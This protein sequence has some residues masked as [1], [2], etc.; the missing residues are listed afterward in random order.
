MYEHG[1]ASIALCECFGMTGDQRVG[2]AAQAALDFIAEAQDPSGGGWRYQPRTPGDTS[3]TGWQVMALKSGQ[4]A[5]LNVST[6][7]LEKAKQFLESVSSCGTGPHRHRRLLRLHRQEQ[8]NR[9]HQ[10]GRLAL[11]PIPGRAED[12]SGDDRRNRL[13]MQNHAGHRRP[14]RTSTTGTMPRR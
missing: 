12:R 4:M 10:R 2:Q 3:V 9:R 6:G 11:L 5:G 7:V 8:A 14:R 1:L 13:L